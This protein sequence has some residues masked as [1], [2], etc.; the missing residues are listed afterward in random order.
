M[1]SRERLEVRWGEVAKGKTIFD[2][3]IIK[4]CKKIVDNM[5]IVGPI[6]VQCI[7]E[8]NNIF[9]IEINARYGGGATL[10]FAAGV[11][12]P[13]W[14]LSIASE[15]ELKLPPIGSY[16]RNLFLSRYDN[17]LFMDE[18]NIKSNSI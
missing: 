11:K 17:S 6:T 15:I 7:L 1:V 3:N 10:G 16:K 2:N 18:K 14:Y 13:H 9:F 5:D 8:D 4:N 12:S